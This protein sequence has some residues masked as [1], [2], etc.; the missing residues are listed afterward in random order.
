MS[1]GNAKNTFSL[2]VCVCVCVCVC[3]LEWGECSS[4][5]WLLKISVLWNQFINIYSP[6]K[7]FW[8]IWMKNVSDQDRYVNH[9][10]CVLNVLFNHAQYDCVQSTCTHE[11]MVL[12]FPSKCSRYSS[13]C[14]SHGSNINSVTCIQHTAYMLETTLEI[15]LEKHGMCSVT[16]SWHLQGTN[17][18]AVLISNQQ[19]SDNCWVLDRWWGVSHQHLVSLY[20]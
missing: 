14:C 17:I 4:A 12:I 15:Q 2:S 19:N 8:L 18:L 3:A 11:L 16:I 20:W 1:V 7:V 10:G 9:V 6:V 5:W 13:S